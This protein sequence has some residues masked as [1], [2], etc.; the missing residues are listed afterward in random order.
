MQSSSFHFLP[1]AP[2]FFFGLVLLFAAVDRAG[3]DRHPG[4]RL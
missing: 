3:A 1:L 4:L 2:L